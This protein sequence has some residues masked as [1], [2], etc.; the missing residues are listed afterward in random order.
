MKIAIVDN[1]G[2]RELLKNPQYKRVDKYG[3][4]NVGVEF[5]DKEVLVLLIKPLPQDK[6]DYL[7]V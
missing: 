5:A 7:E 1:I 6:I 2:E 3:R 4:L